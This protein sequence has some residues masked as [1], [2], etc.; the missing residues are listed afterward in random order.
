MYGTSLERKG[1]GGQEKKERNHL[2]VSEV[3]SKEESGGKTNWELGKGG[4]LI[5]YIP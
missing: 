4:G 1:V 2:F 5:K 3:W